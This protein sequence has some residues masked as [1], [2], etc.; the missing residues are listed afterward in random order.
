MLLTNGSTSK[1][2][3]ILMVDSTDHVTPKTGLT[4]TVTKSKNG[5]AFGALSG[6]VAEVAN[7]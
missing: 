5:G 7:G 4:L 1:K 6:S 2:V 3:M